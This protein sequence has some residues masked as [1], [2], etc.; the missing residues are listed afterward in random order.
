M[1]RAQLFFV[2]HFNRMKVETIIEQGID[3]ISSVLKGGAPAPINACMGVGVKSYLQLSAKHRAHI[4]ELVS[5]TMHFVESL[6]PQYPKF[7]EYVSNMNITNATSLLKIATKIMRKKTTVALLQHYLDVYADILHNPRRMKAI[8]AYMVCVLSN[9][10]AKYKEAVVAAIEFAFTFI[11]VVS[12]TD[13]HSKLSD[14]SQSVQKNI[15]RPMYKE[16]ARKK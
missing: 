1:S 8:G 15:M 5:S 9:V 2:A 7:V 16:L 14:M 10:D 13:L 11:Q 12:H 6:K 4:D 3:Q